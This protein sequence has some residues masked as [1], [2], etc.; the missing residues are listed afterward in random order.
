MSCLFDSL[1]E[2]VN[3]H[4]NDLR[5]G[6][7]DFLQTNPK[8]TDDMSAE[9]VVHFES[10][11]PL[12]RYVVNMRQATVMG[13]ATEIKAFCIVFKRNVKVKSEPN[14]KIIEF[15]VSDNYPFVCLRWT[16]G[17]YDPIFD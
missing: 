1:S 14:D 16:G 11:V 4:S 17:H 2:F 5:Q 3:M 6:I 9:I 13:G 15:V 10:G 8:L 7:C 12:E